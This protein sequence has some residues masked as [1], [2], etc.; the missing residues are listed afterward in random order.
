MSLEEIE[1]NRGLRQDIAQA[2]RD[3]LPVYAEC[4]GLMYLCQGIRW[5]ERRYEMVG[6]IPCEVEMC[7]QTQ[8]HG[9]VEVEVVRENPLFPVG[10]TLRGHQFHYSKL[11]KSDGLRFAYKMRRGRGIDGQSDGILHNNVFAT[12]THLHA[13]GVPQW[14]EALVSLASRERSLSATLSTK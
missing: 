6:T 8:G 14:A 7:Q 13:L 3:G 10:L 1:A 4:A 11:T 2:I 5:Q 12:Y 9:Y